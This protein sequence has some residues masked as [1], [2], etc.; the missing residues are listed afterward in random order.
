MT[1]RELLLPHCY[2][3]WAIRAFLAIAIIGGIVMY[4]SYR[5]K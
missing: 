1:L 3:C 4:Y 5:E 2:K